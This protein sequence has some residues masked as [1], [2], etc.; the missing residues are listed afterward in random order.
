MFIKDSLN[1]K[2][3]TQKRNT[4]FIALVSVLTIIGTTLQSS[5]Q[6]HAF[7][8]DEIS[9]F[10][11]LSG[12]DLS[13]NCVALE[14]N[15]QQTVDNSKNISGNTNSNIVSESDNTNIVANGNSSQSERPT[16][17][18]CFEDAGLT[19]Q[20]E[21]AVLG[22]FSV[23]SFEELCN[24]IQGGDPDDVLT[25]LLLVAE[26]PVDLADEIR[27]CLIEAGVVAYTQG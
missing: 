2:L 6:S 27:D 10:N 1:R 9:D 7:N 12:I 18:G 13:N 3:H 19:T 24:Q 22:A 11:G 21:V 15:N 17:V 16:C 26:L 14:C 8:L 5:P 23:N 4:I 25:T 20:Q